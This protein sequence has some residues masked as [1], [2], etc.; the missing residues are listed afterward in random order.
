[1]E[2][3]LLER[4]FELLGKSPALILAALF[5][6]GGWKRWWVWGYQLADAERAMEKCEAEAERWR[7]VAYTGRNTLKDSVAVSEKAVD[8]L[9]AA[10]K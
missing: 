2:K 6:Y 1:M 8:A 9:K 4:A 5:I 10:T 7:E 3:D